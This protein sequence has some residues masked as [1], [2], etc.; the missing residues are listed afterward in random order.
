MFCR[1]WLIGSIPRRVE[2][3]VWSRAVTLGGMKL[4]EALSPSVWIAVHFSGGAVLNVK[5]RPLRLTL[6]EIERLREAEQADQT[7]AMLSQILNIVEDWDLTEDDGE[8]KV[9]L[10]REALVKIPTN[11][12]TAIVT[13][14]ARHQNA[15][16]AAGSSAVG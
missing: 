5:Y 14:A 1:N 7:E 2:F 15:G 13:A 10:T 11:I 4:S 12:F 9:P 6:E 16:E 3:D 8:T